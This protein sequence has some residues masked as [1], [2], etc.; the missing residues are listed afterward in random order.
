[1]H[2]AASAR[3]SIA[4]VSHRDLGTEI[5]QK[6]PQCCSRRVVI[7]AGRPLILAKLE[8]TTFSKLLRISYTGSVLSVAEPILLLFAS[9]FP[10]SYENSQTREVQICIA[11]SIFLDN[12]NQ[13]TCRVS[14]LLLQISGCRPQIRTVKLKP[15][16]PVNFN[17]IVSLLTELR[18]IKITL[19]V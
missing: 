3:N 9:N 5:K 17:G 8:S 6:V 19:P 12:R 10:R 11:V 7:T 13:A 4:T 15:N 1:M 16:F 2:L 18:T 14:A